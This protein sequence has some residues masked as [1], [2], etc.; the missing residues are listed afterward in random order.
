MKVE[1]GEIIEL[2][3][4][5]EYICCSSIED[6]NNTYIY[7]MSNFKPLEIRFAKVLDDSTLNIITNQEE[8]KRI[9]NLFKERGFNV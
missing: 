3:N 2:D 4:G 7:L 5:K 1:V 6:N 9:F 8:K